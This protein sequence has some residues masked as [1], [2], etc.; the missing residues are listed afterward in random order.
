MNVFFQ[1][2]GS[3]GFFLLCMLFSMLSFFFTGCGKEKEET[4]EITLIHGWGSTEADHVA[5]RQIYQDFEKEYP[6]IKINLVS[7]PSS[8]DVITKVE[9]MLTVGEIPDIVFTGGIGRETIYDFMVENDCAVDL[10]P[11]IEEDEAF[12][13]NISE[14]IL[15]YW[16]E[17]ENHLYTVS[18]V[19]LLSGYWYNAKMFQQAGV[20]KIP[21]SWPE[22]IDACK[23]LS[24][25]G[26][27]Q[28][29]KR[30]P[31]I[32][33]TEHILYL[34]DTMLETINPQVLEEIKRQQI[35]IYSKEFTLVMDW[36]GE[37]YQYSD[38]VD[39][40]TYRDTLKSFNNQ[41]T[42]IYINGVWAGSMIDEE[43]EVSYAAFPYLQEGGLSNISSCVG[44][45]LGKSGDSKKEEASVRFIKYMLSEPVA[46]RILTETGQIP[47]NP[48]VEVSDTG[49]NERLFQA[50]SCVKNASRIMETPANIWDSALKTDFGES[51]KLYLE[52]KITLREFDIRLS[53]R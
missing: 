17:G 53:G 36:L 31:I 39:N 33:D 29:E 25:W 10:M 18:D 38:I 7:M 12:R 8:E 44:Y 13:E 28:E 26:E 42:A 49:E 45:I 11:Y 21:R 23:K 5:M 51:T 6:Q 14:S 35:D 47:S 30:I 24:Q 48:K 20:E 15:S 9:D 46:R 19:L 1:R 34:T 41:E 40:Y 22:F 3:A 43:L 4:V 32:L 2:G 52:G 16:T 50:V 37:I 27:R